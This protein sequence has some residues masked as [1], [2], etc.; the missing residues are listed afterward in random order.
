[1]EESKKVVSTIREVGTYPH[2]D[3]TSPKPYVRSQYTTMSTLLT[4]VHARMCVYAR[5]HTSVHTHVY[6]YL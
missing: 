3:L 1:M 5:T 4:V 6:I 2:E